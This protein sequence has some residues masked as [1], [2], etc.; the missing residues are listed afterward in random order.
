[1]KII[2]ESVDILIK[3]INYIIIE[4]LGQY[5]VSTS[6]NIKEDKENVY[7]QTN[8]LMT[9]LVPEKEFEICSGNVTIEKERFYSDKENI[10]KQINIKF[11]MDILKCTEFEDITKININNNYRWN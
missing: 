11:Y 6:S 1:M 2:N 3:H 4:S 5:Y 9:T 7:I 8:Y 10:L